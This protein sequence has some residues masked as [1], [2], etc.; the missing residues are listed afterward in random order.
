MTRTTYETAGRIRVHRTV[1]EIPV[2]GAI[3][4]VILALDDSRG[5]LLASSYEYPGRYTRWDMGFINPPLVLIARAR[6]FRLDALNTRGRVLLPS[7]AEALRALDAVERIATA[8]ASLEGAVRAPAGRFA[9]ARRAL[10][11][12][13]GASPRPLRSLRLRSGL[14]VRADSAAPRASHRAA[15]PRPLSPRRAGHRRPPPGGRHAPELR[16]RGGG[17]LDRGLSALW[18]H[19]AVR[20]DRGGLRQGRSRSRGVCG[21]RSSRA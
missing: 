18:D 4:P 17:P 11:S 8:E 10:P 13:G 1:E 6:G 5:V 15:R 3:E 16:L 9:R 2:A 14:P 21:H 19:Q 20:R 7:I 12:S